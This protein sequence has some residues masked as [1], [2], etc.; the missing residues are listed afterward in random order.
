M[1]RDLWIDP[2]MLTCSQVVT[3]VNR[4]WNPN[5]IILGTHELDTSCPITSLASQ[6]VIQA[7]IPTTAGDGPT[8]GLNL[9]DFGVLAF[10][11]PKI[12]RD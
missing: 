12:S 9:I 11:L 1:I 2:A 4:P 6:E 10:A 7:M 8:D 5:R 3:L